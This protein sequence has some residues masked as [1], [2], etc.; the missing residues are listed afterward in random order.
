MTVL[1]CCGQINVLQS[2]KSAAVLEVTQWVK[3]RLRLRL[4]KTSAAVLQS[5]KSVAV[6]NRC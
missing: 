4:R 6:E 1:Q 5:R 3:L 2:N